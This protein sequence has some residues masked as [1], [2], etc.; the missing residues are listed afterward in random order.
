M[1][2]LLEGRR[3]LSAGTGEAVA[4]LPAAAARPL[5]VLYFGSS[6]CPASKRF[7]PMLV[8]FDE[9]V[10][11]QPNALATVFHV[12]SDHSDEAFR[13]GLKQ[14]PPDWLVLDFAEGAHAAALANT[15]GVT[16]LP[17]LVVLRA[18]DGAVVSPPSAGRKELV[19]GP[20][21]AVPLWASRASSDELPPP[22]A[23]EAPRPPSPASAAAAAA[24]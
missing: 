6:W 20:H 22:P 4:S 23:L 15:L 1:G 2:S 13:A 17:S 8:D 24:G 18:A 14:L 10:Q 21:R 19:T 16:S 12:S 5:I 3:W 9:E 7:L 11:D